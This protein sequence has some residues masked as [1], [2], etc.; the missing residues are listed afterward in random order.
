MYDRV[1]PI[2]LISKDQ[3][4]EAGTELQEVGVEVVEAVFVHP[5]VDHHSDQATGEIDLS[6]ST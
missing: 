6:Y 5:A 2:W 3:M 4:T 1:Y